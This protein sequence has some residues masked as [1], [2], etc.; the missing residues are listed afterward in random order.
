MLYCRREFDDYFTVCVA[1]YPT[2]KNNQK[3][4]NSVNRGGGGTRCVPPPELSGEGGVN[5]AES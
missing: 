4:V 1:G 3:M 2:G 5:N